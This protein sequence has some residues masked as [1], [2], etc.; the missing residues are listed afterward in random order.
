MTSEHINQDPN[1]NQ[2]ATFIPSAQNQFIIYNRCC[3][4]RFALCFGSTS[5]ALFLSFN[6]LFL[7]SPIFRMKESYLS[8]KFSVN[9]LLW[10]IMFV[11]AFKAHY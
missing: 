3:K 11:R 6:H 9:P 5:I 1:N 7:S 4:R 8:N 10:I 2:I